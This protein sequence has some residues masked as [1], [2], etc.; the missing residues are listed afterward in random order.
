MR[1]DVPQEA[2]LADPVTIEPAY[3]LSASLSQP[4]QEKSKPLLEIWDLTS[5]A[6]NG[7]HY[8]LNLR[9]TRDKWTGRCRDCDRPAPFKALDLVARIPQQSKLGELLNA[10]GRAT[11]D[12][13]GAAIRPSQADGKY[14][15]SEQPDWRMPSIELS[16]PGAKSDLPGLSLLAIAYGGLHLTAWSFPFP[17][18]YEKIIWRGSAFLIATELIALVMWHWFLILCVKVR[19]ADMGALKTLIYWTQKALSFAYLVFVALGL[20]PYV[21]IYAGARIYLVV[22]CFLQLRAVPIGV[23]AAV[24]KSTHP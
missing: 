17:S 12:Q 7:D 10:N 13:A 24:G 4:W 9:S 3:E 15:R 19:A 5:W 23:Y 8:L 6:I 14:I 1:S 20:P 16:D 21:L 11:T 22:E 18:Q 2:G